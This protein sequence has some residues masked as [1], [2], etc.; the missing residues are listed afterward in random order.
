M[1]RRLSITLVF[2]IAFLIFHGVTASA[3][4]YY[5]VSSVL[6]GKN[7]AY[8]YDPSNY[9]GVYLCSDSGESSVFWRISSSGAQS[10]TFD[11]SGLQRVS[12][13]GCGSR[14][15]AVLSGTQVSQNGSR[16]SQ[17]QIVTHDFTTGKTGICTVNSTILGEYGFALGKN[18]CY[19]LQNDLKTISV[20]SLSGTYQY[21]VTT[22]HPSYRLI[23]DGS[24]GNLYI[25]YD[26]GVYMLKNMKLYDFGELK[27][28]ISLAGKSAI[29]SSDGAIYTVGSSS[30]S[31]FCSI[32]TDKAVYL[33]GK[34]YYQ[35]GTEIY[36]TDKSGELLS[37]FDSGI[38]LK[39]MSVVGSK[40]Y[41]IGDDKLMSIAESEFSE[42]QKETQPGSSIDTP[43]S[44]SSS[45][46]IS[47]SSSTENFGNSSYSGRGGIT[48]SVYYV[49][50]SSMTINGIKSPT[51]I[52]K[53]KQNINYEG[54]KAS[55]ISYSGSSKTSGN[56]GTGF[57][58]NFSGEDYKSY[59]L[60]VPGDIT[61]EGNIN[62]RDVR[63]Y[64]EVLCS[65][66]QLQGAYLQASDINGDGICDTLDLLIAAR[67]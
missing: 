23:F 5:D 10:V 47:S 40:I 29:A 55:F 1:K 30:M 3:Y 6:Q 19:I 39:Y 44:N 59:T 27:T 14:V 26:D 64:M 56:V 43:P 18:C 13:S 50:N 12:F 36:S 22:Y 37:S 62:S 65:A 15:A 4:T 31:Y 28:P 42:I 32:S 51:T 33:G 21:S 24:S 63:L 20:Y 52:A 45:A 8:S 34:V 41:V 38:N 7:L 9:G 46:P 16:I 2:A 11:R 49:D 35:S 54:Y 53:F 60:I 57:K 25:M 66:Q 48:S 17:I 67:Q 58:A 61:G